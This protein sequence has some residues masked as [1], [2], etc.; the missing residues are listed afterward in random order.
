MKRKFDKIQ[1]D[2]GA[3]MHYDAVVID[4]SAQEFVFGSIVASDVAL[5]NIM[6]VVKKKVNCYVEHKCHAVIQ[7]D[8]IVEKEKQTNGDFAHLVMMKKD[9]VEKISDN[10]M[11]TFYIISRD[12]EE[13]ES[14]LYDK[15]YDNTSIPIMR[16]WMKYIFQHF[17][18]NHNIREMTV[19]HRYEDGTEPFRAHKVCFT[20]SGLL[21]AVQTGLRSGNIN[22]DNQRES[23]TIMNET[24]GLDMYL[25]VFGDILA[26][27]IQ[28]AFV[29]KYDPK[30]DEYSEYVNNYDDS[31]H[32]AG[33]ELFEAQKA[34]IQS[35]VNNL[36]KNKTT[37]V[38]GEMGCGV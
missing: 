7:G 10:E 18:I 16:D 35:A 21:D 12:N 17:S 11:Y 27:K 22:I 32:Y 36:D 9:V 6:K 24:N 14:V 19:Y 1:I 3:Y 34:V 5:K 28:R 15:L 20:K 37:I 26:D 30:R 2:N 25:N 38:V 31:C 23:S 29:P 8:F 33:I 4:R 13:L